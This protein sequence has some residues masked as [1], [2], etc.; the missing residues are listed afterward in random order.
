MT[1]NN[2]DDDTLVYDSSVDKLTLWKEILKL[3]YR[4][5]ELEGKVEDLQRIVDSPRFF[6]EK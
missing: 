4:V 3:R 1:Q 5:E 2:D 6:G